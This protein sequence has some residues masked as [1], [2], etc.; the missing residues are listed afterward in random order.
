MIANSI[1]QG[2]K[3]LSKGKLED[4]AENSASLMN[5][6]TSREQTAYYFQGRKEE[7]SELIKLL[8]DMVQNP[9]LN[10]NRGF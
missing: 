1:F 9:T 7:T 8:A 3:L 10:K 4:Y 6:Y 5:A 2:S